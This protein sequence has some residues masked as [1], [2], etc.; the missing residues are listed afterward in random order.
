MHKSHA[1]LHAPVVEYPG[2]KG[3]L[4][5]LVW[6]GWVRIVIVEGGSWG[7][8]KKTMGFGRLRSGGGRSASKLG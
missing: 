5:R 8:G 1:S 6:K 4:L 3:G 2:A 7:N